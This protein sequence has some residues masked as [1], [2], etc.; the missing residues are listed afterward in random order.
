[1]SRPGKHAVHFSDVFRIRPVVL[2]NYGA[3]DVA[4]LNDL[5]LFVDPFLLYDSLNPEYR[6]LHDE[7]IDY[8]VFLKERAQFGELDE[9]N[10]R[11]WLLFKEVHQN[12][13]GFCTTGNRG[14]GLGMDFARSLAKNLNGPFRNFG[15]ET[16]TKSSH[17]EK[18]GLLGGVGRDHLSDFV[19]NL[20]KRYLLEFTQGFASKHLGANQVASFAV[21]KVRFDY[22][23]RR[24]LGGTYTLPKL[25]D[26]YVLLTPED[27]LTRDESWINQRDMLG[28][29]SRLRLSLPNDVLRR[30]VE[31]HFR[32]QIGKRAKEKEKR[33]AALRTITEFPELM[34]HYIALKEDQAPAAHV[35]SGKKVAETYHQFVEAVRDLA[36]K[37]LVPGHFYDHGDSYEES[38]NRVRFLKRVIEDKDGYRAFWGKNGKP[39]QRESDLHIMF[40]LVWFRSPFDANAEVNN[41]RGPVDFKVSKGS[42]DSCL[43]EFKLASNSQLKKNLANQ[44]AIYEKANETRRSIKVILY[45]TIA[46]HRKVMKMLK[47]LKLEGSSDIVLIDASKAK[48][49]ASKAGPP[50]ARP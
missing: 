6:K 39:I 21:D 9:I 22:E 46:E 44:V 23:Q 20:I 26:D 13:L 31:E 37:H 15:D 35:A 45:F 29:F 3:F 19:T 49:S 30:N 24:W 34:D 43:V 12:W 8:L 17:I 7:I 40:K 42:A 47:D 36:D 16:L 50:A 4:L 2:A 5:P 48:P 28:Q 14:T 18:L 1:M 32:R 38:M 25:A 33:L 10:I 11:R 27:I 41:G